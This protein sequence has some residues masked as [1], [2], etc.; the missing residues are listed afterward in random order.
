M[1][2]NASG[3]GSVRSSAVLNED[4]R[5]LWERAGGRLNPE[6][7]AEYEQLVVEWAEAVRAEVMEAA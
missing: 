5:A 6:Q 3:L 7:R 4:I 2:P 1:P